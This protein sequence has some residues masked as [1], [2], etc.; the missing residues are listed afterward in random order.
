MTRKCKEI[1]ETK[2]LSDLLMNPSVPSLLHNVLLQSQQYAAVACDL[3]SRND[4]NALADL[5][6]GDDRQILFLAEVSM[7]YMNAAAATQLIEWSS[8]F[9][10]GKVLC[11]AYV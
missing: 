4:R 3:Q 1:Q 7:T 2:H 9:P 5:L 8:A 6:H 10:R 11:L